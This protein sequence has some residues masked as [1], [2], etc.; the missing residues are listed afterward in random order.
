M[1]LPYV[2]FPTGAQFI[3]IRGLGL[4]K[5]SSEALAVQKFGPGEVGRRLLILARLER[6]GHYCRLRLSGDY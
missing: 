4:G 5:H 6:H 2:P 1:I 3:N